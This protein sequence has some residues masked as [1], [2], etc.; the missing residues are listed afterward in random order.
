M[1]RSASPA[2]MLAGDS[3][4]AALVREG[5]GRR[6]PRSVPVSSSGGTAGHGGFRTR[7]GGLLS[8]AWLPGRGGPRRSQRRLRG[9]EFRCLLPSS[10]WVHREGAA[11]NPARPVSDSGLVPVP[12]HPAASA[13]GAARLTV[14]CTRGLSVRTSSVP[15]QRA[16]CPVLS[17]DEGQHRGDGQ[18]LGHFGSG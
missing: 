13:P 11:K 12:R 14:R 8:G 4:E 6:E 7:L 15:G 3:C 1:G 5:G 18:Q 2:A 17:F 16:F 10:Q 9:P